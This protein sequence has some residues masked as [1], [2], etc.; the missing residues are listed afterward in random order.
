[1]KGRLFTLTGLAA[2]LFAAMMVSSGAAAPIVQH[3]REVN[4]GTF[5]EPVCGIEGTHVATEV[6][7]VQ[8]LGNGTMKDEFRFNDVFT[9]TASGKSLEIVAASPFTS[10]RTN[11][12][13][14]TITSVFTVKGLGAKLKL[15]NGRVLA[16]NAGVLTNVLT[17]RVN[18][19]GSVD[20]VS[21]SSSAVGRQ[22]DIGGSIFNIGGPICDEIV[23]ALT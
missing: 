10:T 13:D 2:A 12:A 19:D 23:P 17:Y 20:I 15:P 14:G 22:D 16:V 11:N 21:F 8:V 1:M 7:N 4:S 18:P 3:F 9:A 6:D 5:S